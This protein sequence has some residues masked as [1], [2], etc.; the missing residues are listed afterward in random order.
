MDPIALL[1]KGGFLM[2]PLLLLSIFTFGVIIF[3]IIQFRKIKILKD[4]ISEEL[5]E[6]IKAKKMNKAKDLTSNSDGLCAQVLDSSVDVLL[7]NK[8]PNDK[9]ILEIERIGK[10]KIS[11]LEQYM[12]GL[13]MVSATAPLIGL[14]GT[15]MGM[16]TA[17]GKIAESKS[18]VDPSLLAGG[19]WEALVTTVGGLLVAIPALIAWYVINSY[20]EKARNNLENSAQ[21]LYNVWS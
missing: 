13:E 15:V 2:I 12:K 10:H 9:K 20:I 5:A 6:L 14:L 3:K 11:S 1:S 19:I 4:D 17:F 8:I 16:V 21:K 7:S 18:R